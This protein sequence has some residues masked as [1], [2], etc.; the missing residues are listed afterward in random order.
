MTEFDERKVVF[1]PG[2]N[3]ASF[4][5][6]ATLIYDSFYLFLHTSIHYPLKVQMKT[7]LPD[8][9]SHYS[10]TDKIPLL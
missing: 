10:F 4:D 1:H 3:A 8:L 5:I 6:S 7:N 2:K 9:R